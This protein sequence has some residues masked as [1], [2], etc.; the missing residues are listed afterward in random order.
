MCAETQMVQVWVCTANWQQANV[1]CLSL[2]S[3]IAYYLVVQDRAVYM[4]YVV[5][6]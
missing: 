6:M 5:Y 3:A 4:L 1:S 2:I